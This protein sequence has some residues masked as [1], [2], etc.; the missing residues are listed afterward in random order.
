MRPPSV[1]WE[2]YTMPGCVICRR[3][4][5]FQWA[6]AHSRTC[7]AV[8]LPSGEASSITLCPVASTEP[9]SCTEMWP[10]VGAMTPWCGRSAAHITMKLA[11]VPPMRKWTA[12]SGAAHFSRIISAAAAQ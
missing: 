6:A 12:A 5:S 10:S 11:C 4:G 3:L 8:S 7:P 2:M 9:A 1:G